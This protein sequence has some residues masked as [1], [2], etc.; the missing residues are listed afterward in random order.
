MRALL[1]T[2]LALG[3]V[4]CATTTPQ[5]TAKADEAGFQSWAA[6]YEQ[7][8]LTA[9]YDRTAVRNVMQSLTFQPR[10]IELDGKQPEG[11]MTLQQYIERT[12]DAARIN[13]GR[14]KFAEHAAI[15]RSVEQ[16]TGVP[17][18]VIVALWGKE[19]TYGGFT[20][21]YEVGDAL[22]TLA[23]DGR[24]RDMFERELAAF[25][26]IVQKLE[27]DPTQLKGS[28]AGAMGQCQFMPTSYLKYAADGD[29]DGK[30]DIWTSLPD[31]FASTA[32]FLKQSGWQAGQPI[33]QPII[34]P[35]T[36]NAAIIGRDKPAR[37]LQDWLNAGVKIMDTV[38]NQN[39]PAR[40]YAPDVGGPAFIIYPNFDVLMRWNAS[41]YFATGVA[42]LADQISHF[43]R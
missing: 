20:G 32:N 11:Q 42:S 36:I 29:G 39:L 3:L 34:L 9:G 33:A 28:W 23:Y 12:V 2:F 30:A 8:A 1:L 43:E 27:R 13:K 18:N 17:A 37:P 15:L 31:V 40:I 22:G 14:E 19:T 16:Q 5:H 41:G 6:A 25:I 10:I 24:R 4:A 35:S 21:G 26:Q 7:R 38:P